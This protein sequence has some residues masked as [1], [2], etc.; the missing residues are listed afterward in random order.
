MF[1]VFTGCTGMI[2]WI[3]AKMIICREI[4]L[5]KTFAVALIIF[6]K[7]WFFAFSP[8]HTARFRAPLKQTLKD[9]KWQCSWSFTR[10][11]SNFFVPSFSPFSPPCR[12]LLLRTFHSLPFK[13]FDN[14]FS[15]KISMGFSTSK[16]NISLCF[17]DSHDFILRPA[18]D[19]CEL[20][21]TNQ[22][23]P[24]LIW[25]W[26]EILFPSDNDV[27]FWNG[28]KFEERARRMCNFPASPSTPSADKCCVIPTTNFRAKKP[29]WKSIHFESG[30]PINTSRRLNLAK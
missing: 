27:N 25:Q 20:V 16:L 19:K 13:L 3:W 22:W 1:S 12:V 30:T 11:S 29:N 4:A 8:N 7:S 2:S 17:K 10:Q 15:G 21:S 9:T 24:L 18:H 5:R 14:C 28:W 6:P 23:D 26:C